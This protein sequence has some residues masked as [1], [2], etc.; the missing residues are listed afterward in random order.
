MTSYNFL[1]LSCL[2]ILS[3][4]H[5]LLGQERAESDQVILNQDILF[6]ELFLTDSAPLLFSKSQKRGMVRSS[7]KN[8]AKIIRA[9]YQV[10]YSGQQCHNLL[11]KFF[12]LV[13]ECLLHLVH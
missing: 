8:V 13:L 5:V 10:S 1:D 11:F 7:Y 12:L 4:A 6:S 3:L 9:A 2:E